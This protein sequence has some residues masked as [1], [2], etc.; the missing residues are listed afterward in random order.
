MTVSADDLFQQALQLPL[1]EQTRLL[2]ALAARLPIALASEAAS[3]AAEP[4]EQEWSAWLQLVDQ[5]GVA[6]GIADLAHQHGHYVHGAPR[7]EDAA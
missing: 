3:A 2:A 5:Y 1:A 7:K 4:P 6:T